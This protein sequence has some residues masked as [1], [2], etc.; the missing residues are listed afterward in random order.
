MPQTSPPLPPPPRYSAVMKPEVHGRPPAPQPLSPQLLSAPAFYELPP[1]PPYSVASRDC[2]QT[3]SSRLFAL[4]P[5]RYGFA[6]AF[7]RL[8]ANS[9]NLGN[10]KRAIKRRMF[11]TAALV[12]FVAPIL[13]FV[14]IMALANVF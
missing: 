11:V 10:R 13:L 1:P 3:T 9:V 8:R 4:S 5:P 12:F 6:M 2:R 7:G 14:I